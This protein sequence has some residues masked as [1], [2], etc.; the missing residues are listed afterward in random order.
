MAE[1]AITEMIRNLPWRQVC[2]HIDRIQG[3]TFSFMPLNVFFT[4]TPTPSFLLICDSE[5][6]Q[7]PF[8]HCLMSSHSSPCLE[9]NLLLEHHPAHFPVQPPSSILAAIAVPG[10]N[11]KEAG[12]GP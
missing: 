2:E 5:V 9:A 10:S 4:S 12:D 8:T 3:N 1:K 6:I 11:R 7:L